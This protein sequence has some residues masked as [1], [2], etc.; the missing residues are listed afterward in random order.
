MISLTVKEAASLYNCSDQYIRKKISNRE[1]PAEN[2]GRAGYRIPLSALEPALQRKWYQQ[3]KQEIPPELRRRQRKPKEPPATPQS[4]DDFTGAEREQ[5]ECWY[6]IIGGWRNYRSAA[7]KSKA[8]AD[9]E[10]IAIA[11]AQYPDMQISYDVLT[12]KYTDLKAGNL[13]GVVDKRG[14]WRKGTTT[15]PDPVRDIFDYTYLDDACLSVKKCYEMTKLIVQQERPELA[16]S[17]PAYDAFW[18]YTKTLPVPTV[19]LA[20]Y[21]DKAFNDRCGVFVDRLYDD[22]QSNDYWIADGHTI[23][24]ISKAEDGSDCRHRLTLSAFIDAR[25]GIYVGWVVTDNPSSD[26]TLLALRKAI[27][28]YGIPRNIYVDNGREYLNTDI[29]GLGHR[30]KKRTKDQSPLPTPILTRLG[31]TMTNALPRNG[32]A[33]II[34][35]EF[36]NF[37]F[38]SRLF[39]SYCGN[40]PANRPERLKHHL[41]AGHIPTDGELAR[42]VDDMIE[43]YFNVQTYNGKVKADCGKTKMQVYQDHLH[44][45]RKANEEDLTLMLMRSTRLQTIARNGVY[46][47][48]SGERVYYYSDELL[49]HMRQKVYLRYNPENLDEVRVYDE[50]EKYLMTV[51]MRRELMLE[52]GAGKEEISRAMAEK[53]RFRRLA[54]EQINIT[55]EK[56]VSQ[57]GHIN[58]LDV[59]VRAARINRDGLLSGGGEEPKVYEIVRANDEKELPA[60]VGGEEP[61]IID[62]AR[63]IRNLERREQNSNGL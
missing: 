4:I 49:F 34:E 14:K 47:T 51:P 61:A 57:Y 28:R 15:I 3:H 42:V 19:T 25:S 40:N 63:M 11:R 7:G 9:R 12:R 38:L 20:R 21:G 23:D 44:S 48:V 8:E 52:Y 30:K 41:K 55:R 37:T 29:G 39:E 45:V 31:I 18:R 43:G 26:A 59:F 16:D 1:I 58:A 32:Q 60:A 53:R 2:H 24:V 56:V 13:A 50:Q 22:M 54:K 36:R 10:Y 27:L 33:K 35:R 62:R 17:I 5:I 46:I 6:H